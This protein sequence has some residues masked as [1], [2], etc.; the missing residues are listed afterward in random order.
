MKN[1]FPANPILIVD[2]EKSILNSME[3]TFRS[4]GYTN[5]VCL[6]QSKLVMDYLNAHSVEVVFLD[7]TMP[8]ISGDKILK[9]ITV[10]FP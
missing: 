6:Q 3:F 8:V 2:D 4:D 5:I 10:H 1:L 9:E 7:I